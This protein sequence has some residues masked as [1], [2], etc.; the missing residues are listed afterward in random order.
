MEWSNQMNPREKKIKKNP[1]GN[2]DKLDVTISDFFLI[3]SKTARIKSTLR[4]VLLAF[5]FLGTSWLL[6]GL[7]DRFWETTV[8]WRSLILAIGLSSAL[9]SVF[10]VISYS[11]Y[12]TRQLPWLA[13]SVRKVYRTK[14]E[15][16]LG[17][18]EIAEEE[19][20][21]IRSYST[22]IF[23]AAQDKMAKEIKSLQV[24]KIFPWKKVRIPSVSAGG[25]FMVIL[26]AF[27]LYPE[28]SKNVLKRWAFPFSSVERI[29]FTQILNDEK[30]I[31]TIL[32]N[33]PTTIRF[34]ISPYSRTK[35]NYAELHNSSESKFSL[36]SSLNGGIYEFNIPP[37]KEDFSFELT[38]GDYCK[39]F[40]VKTIKRPHLDSLSS[41][42]KFPDYLSLKTKKF[43]ILN[44]QIKVPENSEITLFAQA[45]RKINQVL[46]T[47]NRD[48]IGLRPY[49]KN[50][51]IKLPKFNDDKRFSLYLIDSYGFSQ[52]EPT[53]VFFKLQKDEPPKTNLNP[54]CDTSPVM[55]FETR[56]ITFQNE[57]DFGLSEIS[58][59]LSIFRDQKKTNEIEIYRNKLPKVGT[60]NSDLVFP[61]D[62]SLFEMED[63][64]EVIFIASAKDNFPAREPTRSKP[65]KMQIVGPEKHAEMI[66][67][68]IDGVISEISEIAR[69]QEAIQFETLSV[70]ERVRKSSDQQLG[71]KQTGEIS[72]LGNDQND[73]AKRLNATARNGSNILDEAAKNPLFDPELLQEFASSLREIK[74]TSSG[75]MSESERKLNS[76]SRSD[77]S[78][79][80][81]AM[82]QSAEFQ[83]RALEELRKVLAKFS[84]QLDRLEART[85]AER[86]KK[87]EKT[88]YK[89]SNKLVTIMA[90]SVGRMPSQLDNN[91]LSTFYEMEKLQARVSEDADEVMNEISRYHERTQKVEYGT[92]SQMMKEANPKIG[93]SKVSDN[94]RNN[95][96]FQALDKLN[97]WESSFEEWARLLQQ[98]SPGGDSAGGG[99][100]K[101]RTA[102]IL[103]LLKMR[104]IQSDILFKTKT[105]DQEGFRG[106]KEVWSLSLKDQQD[107]LMID[108]TDTQI[109][110]AEEA[111][112]PLF[113]DAHMEM[114]ESSQQL[115]KQIFDE[116]TQ[117]AQKE[118][119]NI[120]SDLINLLLEGQGQGQGNSDN[121][122]LTA[123]EL[124]MMQMGNEKSG[125]ANGNSPVP[126]NTGGGSSQGGS[127]EQ[128]TKSLKG[129]TLAPA[130]NDSSSKSSSNITPSIAPE[131][132]EAMEKYFKAIE[133]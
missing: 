40:H 1:G 50:F 2:E 112:N 17:I 91:N 27:I 88:E 52:R 53:N 72:S 59:S 60:K 62:P 109:S 18:I 99:E 49:S 63:G 115:S 55:L 66:R 37:Q 89:I 45:N 101:D 64:D 94:I 19:K 10:R 58:L 98:E 118:S 82:M 67:S 42:V 24:G 12:Y 103:S 56:K 105:L 75:T 106:R 90:S 22:Q 122:N 70:E 8:I 124:L 95:I 11:F 83:Q 107:T 126:G 104:K 131:F 69:N 9:W 92:V 33:E 34:S 43:D 127:V 39:T 51:S 44:S 133:D 81:Q 87:L 128:V 5:S 84:K 29:T 31:F 93:L 48:Q 120:I 73:L 4:F 116:G 100:G 85:L 35:P 23:K 6:L 117:A 119:K 61:F 41:V 21:G 68:Q 36:I 14:G 76:A 125:S 54:S 71:S 15:R 32:E 114:S 132:K 78:Q 80:S 102:D 108:L 13:K 16:L 47:E 46:M 25:V 20:I 38:V 113:D 86:L 7:S 26:L 74:E 121:E 77:P 28:I 123:M 110:I 111:L 65:L 3:L 30:K 129:S 57:D 79:A 96:S 97:Y 130:K